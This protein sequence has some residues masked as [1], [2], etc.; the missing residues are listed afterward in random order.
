MGF[1]LRLLEEQPFRLIVRTV[2][3]RLPLSVRTYERWDAVERPHYLCG[4]LAAADLAKRSGIDSIYAIEFGVARGNG[5]LA[6]Q[7]YAQMVERETGVKIIVAGFDTGAGLPPTKGDY[8]DHPDKW[9]EG[10]FPMDEE[11]LRARLLPGTELILGDVRHTVLAFV[12]R[13]RCPLGFMAMDLDLYS[14]TK[15]ALEILRLPK[16]QMLRQVFLYFDDIIGTEYHRFAGERLA[17]EDFNH[18]NQWTKID[19]WYALCS[20][21][22]RDY[23]WVK[24]MYVAHDI[25]TIN[26][27]H[28]E[29]EA[30]L[31]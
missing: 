17:I 2:V 24:Q 16:R 15:Q 30:Q 31:M 14:S 10:D 9:I 1:L 6:M 5:L 18:E 12:E 27:Y 20:R 23:A 28:A 4:I 29:R 11:W 8:R 25:A 26:D 7:R 22:F 19:H 21:I 3:K 13:Q